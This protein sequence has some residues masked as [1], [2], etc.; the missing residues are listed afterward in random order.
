MADVAIND[1]VQLTGKVI[2]IN[3][4]IGGTKAVVQLPD[5][6]LIEIYTSHLELPIPPPEEPPP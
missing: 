1:E 6:S 3:N 4:Y 5:E 2:A